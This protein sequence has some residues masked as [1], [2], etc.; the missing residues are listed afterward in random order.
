M[1]DL[2]ALLILSLATWRIAVLAVREDGPWDLALR[3]RERLGFVYYEDG[4]VAS[5][6]EGMPGAILRCVWCTSAWVSGPMVGLWLVLPLVVTG[7]AVAA[8][9]VLVELVAGRLQRD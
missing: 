6:P 5:E 2:G 8:G 3:L 7:V 9:A 1:L 4:S